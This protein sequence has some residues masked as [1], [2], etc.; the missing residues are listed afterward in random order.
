MFMPLVG[1]EGVKCAN[2]ENPNDG[3][4]YIR[5]LEIQI[6]QFFCFFFNEVDGVSYMGDRQSRGGEI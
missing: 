6:N 3:A 4:E 1:A 5:L 2:T